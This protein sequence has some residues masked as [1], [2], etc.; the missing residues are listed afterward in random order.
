MNLDRYQEIIKEIRPYNAQ[1]IAVS[2]NKPVADIS[3]LYELGQ[4][5]FGE[6]KVQEMSE[7]HELLPKDIN[8]HFI[9]HLQTNKVKYIAP[10][11]ALIHGVDSLRLLE[12]INK[13][14]LKSNRIIP[15]LLQIHIAAEETKFGMDNDELLSLLSS[16]TYRSL[17]NTQICGLM[18]MATNT[19]DTAQ[20]EKEF[21]SLKAL[22]DKLK[23]DHF[24]DKPYFKDLSMGMSSD[25]HI[26]LR[27]GATLIRIGS[28]IFGTR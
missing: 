27:H 4:R 22:F 15:C 5:D 19:D 18:G 6:N 13:Q 9:G 28:D 25:Y 8:W 24:S 11:V 7:K 21:A 3:A 10:F 20:V 14:A 12:E 17:R 16:P 23:T 26:A 2:K 1:L